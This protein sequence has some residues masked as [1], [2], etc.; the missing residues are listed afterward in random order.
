MITKKIRFKEL[1]QGTRKFLLMK[2]GK[3]LFSANLEVTRKCNLRCDF[4]NYWK[5]NGPNTELSR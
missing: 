1:I 2:L 3:T 5:P 4:C